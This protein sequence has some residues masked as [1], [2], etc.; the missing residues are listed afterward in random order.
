MLKLPFPL[1]GICLLIVLVSCE[2]DTISSEIDKLEVNLE[3]HRFD[4]A[5]ATATPADLPQLKATYPFL[6]PQQ[7]A[8]SIWIQK[9]NDTLQQEIQQEVKLAFPDFKKETKELTLLYKHLRYYFPTTPVPKV[10]TLAEEVDY[11]N[12]IIA[13]DDFLLI[14]LDNYLGKEHRFYQGIYTYVAALQDKEYLLADV[15]EAYSRKLVPARNERSFLSQMIYY[16]KLRYVMQ[17]L[18]PFQEAHQ[19]LHYT[20]SQ[21]QWA[22]A[23]ETQIWEYFVTNDLLFS[24][25]QNL[26]DRFI[27]LGPYSKFYLELDNESPPRLGQYIGLRIV[28]D[29]MKKNPSTG[30]DQLLRMN[31][32]SIFK[33]AAFKPKK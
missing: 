18:L 27:N 20:E 16:G 1:V 19:H 8:D 28:Q 25:D 2:K 24:T 10:V 3:V 29:F 5:F 26:N 6:F 9:M 31:E 13:T 15:A 30:L 12:K 33:Q 17:T 4:R 14:S 32:E 11:R 22:Q 23:N 7:F 21:L